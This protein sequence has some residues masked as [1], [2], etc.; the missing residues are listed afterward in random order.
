M[1][2]PLLWRGSTEPGRLALPAGA[3]G[4]VRRLSPDGAG[5]HTGRPNRLYLWGL[6]RCAASLE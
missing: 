3:R 2:G 5:L 4:G 1:R 6:L